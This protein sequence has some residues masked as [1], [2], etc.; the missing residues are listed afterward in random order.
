MCLRAEPIRQ[1]AACLSASGLL[2]GMVVG[3]GGLERFLAA[4]TRL[5]VRTRWLY[6]SGARSRSASHNHQSDTPALSFTGTGIPPD[7]GCVCNG[8]RHAVAFLHRHRYPTGGLRRRHTRRSLQAVRCAA[9]RRQH[10]HAWLAFWSRAAAA[11]VGPADCRRYPGYTSLPGRAPRSAAPIV[12]GAGALSFEGA[13]VAGGRARGGRTRRGGS[14]FTPD[15]CAPVGGAI[16]ALRPRRDLQVQVR[17][18]GGPVESMRKACASPAPAPPLAGRSW[19]TAWLTS[20]CSASPWRARSSRLSG[21]AL[22]RY[23]RTAGET[24]S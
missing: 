18:F 22:C 11:S 1:H 16:P 4:R 23:R 9:G 24:R 7:C 14:I 19:S 5:R 17:R 8:H 2:F 12:V 6:Y 13:R 15:T 10:R 3:G 20:R 21:P